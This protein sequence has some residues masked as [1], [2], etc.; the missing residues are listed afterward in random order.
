MA[1]VQGTRLST[2]ADDAWSVSIPHSG[3]DVFPLRRFRFYGAHSRRLV[4]YWY[5]VDGMVLA[6]ISWHRGNDRSRV[7]DGH[8]AL[9]ALL[10]TVRSKRI[11][12]SIFGHIVALLHP[13]LSRKR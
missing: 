8:L 1:F 9:Y 12:C 2:Y 7:S 13:A 11:V 5:C 3:V 4:Q 6:Q 10:R